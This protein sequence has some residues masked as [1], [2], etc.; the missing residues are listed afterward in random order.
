[1]EV[2]VDAIFP[3]PSHEVKLLHRGPCKSLPHFWDFL[4]ERFLSVL[5]CALHNITHQFDSI[6]NL[7]CVCRYLLLFKI[8]ETCT[9]IFLQSF[10]QF[11]MFVCRSFYQCYL[12]STEEAKV[13]L[14]CSHFHLG[15]LQLELNSIQFIDKYAPSNLR[16]I[17]SSFF[18]PIFLPDIT[19]KTVIL[20]PTLFVYSPSVMGSYVDATE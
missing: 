14:T 9:F 20:V 1:M 6:V 2:P 12:S 7:F 18:Q 3:I 15:H 19:F 8:F 4:V 11:L 10:D 16:H 5:Q 13:V 17:H